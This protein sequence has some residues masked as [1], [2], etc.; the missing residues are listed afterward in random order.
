MRDLSS[1]TL[2]LTL[3]GRGSSKETFLLDETT[4]LSFYLGTSDIRNISLLLAHL[5]D[6]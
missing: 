5:K 1:G 6:T 4:I 3:S 2:V